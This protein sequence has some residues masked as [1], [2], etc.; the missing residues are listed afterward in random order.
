MSDDNNGQYIL[1]VDDT[2][3]NIDVI[4]G[5]L[6]DTYQIKVATNGENALRIARA[7]PAP[8]LI[9]LDII[10]PGMDG[11]Q[12]CR[13][14]KQDVRTQRIP[15]IFLTARTAV[16]DQARGFSLGAVDYITKPVSAPIVEARVRTHLS[17]YSQASHLESLVRARTAE[18][19]ETRLQI[20]QRLGIAAE[21][22]DNETGMHILRVAHVCRLLGLAA[23]MTGDEADVLFHASPMHDVGKIGI[24]DHILLKPGKLNEEEWAIMKKHT[25]IGAK[26]LG[27]HASEPLRMARI[28]A[29]THHEKWNG[30]GYPEGLAG[31]A[32]PLP[33]RIVALADVFD[34]LT[35]VRPYKEAWP[36]EKAVQLIEEESGQHFDPGLVPIILENLPQ[37]CSISDQYVDTAQSEARNDDPSWLAGLPIAVKDLVGHVAWPNHR[38]GHDA[39]EEDRIA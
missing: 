10:M 4:S 28:I 2:S 6:A 33:G 5:I 14:L 8:D 25:T 39:A 36:V 7:E 12:V 9:L 37:I 23:G 16:E 21:F 31:E 35:S 38:A 34:A 24:P 11:Y 18:L 20:I 1:V 29:L 19:S 3:S 32:I 15:V 17:L 27:D 30:K 13:E 22:K 26:I